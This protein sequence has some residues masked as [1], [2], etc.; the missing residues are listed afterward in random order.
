MPG[1]RQASLRFGLNSLLAQLKNVLSLRVNVVNA[2]KTLKPRQ[3]KKPMANSLLRPFQPRMLIGWL[4]C[5][6]PLVSFLSQGYKIRCAQTPY[7]S[8]LPQWT[9]L[10]KMFVQGLALKAIQ[11]IYGLPAIL[12]LFWIWSM[13]KPGAIPITEFL[14]ALRL[15]KNLLYVLAILSFAAVWFAPSAV[16]SYA[17]ENRFG[18]AFSAQVLRR[19]LNLAY[20]K[21][22][23]LASIC[24]LASWAV[25]AG[26]A[27]TLAGILSANSI[28]AMCFVGIL[29]FVLFAFG[30]AYWTILAKSY[31]RIVYETSQQQSM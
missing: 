19:T 15:V 31:Y 23:I 8:E 24:A 5:F 1:S 28:T 21:G 30:I 14:P 26:V 22:W 9:N 6:V 4:L 12:I 10:K 29:Y 7:E 20:L 25:I 17:F 27:A 2:I 18:A 11:I 16:L 3:Y 13:A